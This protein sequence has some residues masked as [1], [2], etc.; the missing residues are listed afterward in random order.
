MAL[1]RGTEAPRL[2]HPPTR[3]F[4]FSGQAFTHG[5]QTHKIDSVPVRNKAMLKN[6]LKS[7]KLQKETDCGALCS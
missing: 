6:N 5:I 1:E 3:I 2:A 4:W 7:F